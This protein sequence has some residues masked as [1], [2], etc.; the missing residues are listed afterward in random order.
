MFTQK[1]YI[2]IAEALKEVNPR[3]DD[4]AEDKHPDTFD[5]FDKVVDVL[6]HLFKMDNEKFDEAKFIK[7]IGE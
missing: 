6:T 1:H 7:A 3:L 4:F 2:A 5:T